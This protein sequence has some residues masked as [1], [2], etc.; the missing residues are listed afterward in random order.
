M[1]KLKEETKQYV[2]REVVEQIRMLKGRNIPMSQIAKSVDL[3]E[4]IV[5]NIISSLTREIDPM[6]EMLSSIDSYS[7]MILDLSS[8]ISDLKESGKETDRKDLSD[9]MKQRA[10]LQKEKINLLTKVIELKTKHT[11]TPTGIAQYSSRQPEE[12]IPI[13]EIQ[14]DNNDKEQVDEELPIVNKKKICRIF[15]YKVLAI[16]SQFGFTLTSLKEDGVDKKSRKLI[17]RA[18]GCTREEFR[19]II[20]RI[21][22]G[23]FPVPRNSV[24]I[25]LRKAWR[26]YEEDEI[27]DEI[28]E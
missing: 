17:I 20:K 1:K 12:K 22:Q 26:K 2:S 16:L 19:I 7:T 14:Q 18:T 6:T 4:D 25:R 13:Q 10:E 3:N 24:E 28:E 5:A 27:S 23:K 9:Y 15:C 21:K 8:L 11:S